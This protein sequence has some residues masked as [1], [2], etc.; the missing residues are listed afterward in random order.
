MAGEL[1]SERAMALSRE[2]STLSA[3]LRQIA[4]WAGDQRVKKGPLFSATLEPVPS[5]AANPVLHGYAWATPR[6]PRQ[7]SKPAG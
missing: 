3:A 6:F 4:R 2:G 7:S 1:A 5:S